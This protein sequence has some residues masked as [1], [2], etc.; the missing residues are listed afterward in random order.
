MKQIKCDIC[1]KEIGIW[2]E[3]HIKPCA[4]YDWQNISEISKYTSNM[5]ICKDCMEKMLERKEG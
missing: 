1:K 4:M 2:L 3:V 5:Q